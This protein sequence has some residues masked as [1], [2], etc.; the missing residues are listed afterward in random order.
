[1]RGE[2]SIIGPPP[3]PRPD[4]LLNKVK[5]GMIQWA[6]IFATRKRRPDDSRLR[7]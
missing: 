6:Q 1:M 7:D 5:P 3:C 2:L 4:P